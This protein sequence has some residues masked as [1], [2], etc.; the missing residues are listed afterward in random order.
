MCLTTEAEL[1]AEIEAEQ[2]GAILVLTSDVN[3]ELSGWD[4]SGQSDGV[5]EL[6]LASRKRALEVGVVGSCCFANIESTSQKSDETKL[7]YDISKGS[8]LC[9]AKDQFEEKERD[10]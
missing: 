5:L 8:I 10:G 9:M 2:V 3:V 4:L 7:D 6:V 1:D